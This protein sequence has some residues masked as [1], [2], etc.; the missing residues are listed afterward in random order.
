MSACICILTAV[1]VVE[2]V[3]GGLLSIFYLTQLSHSDI[4][5]VGSMQMNDKEGAGYITLEEAMQIMYLRYGR[6]ACDQ[7][8]DTLTLERSWRI[9]VLCLP[10]GPS[11][12]A[13]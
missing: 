12:C 10:Q 11:G 6:C 3:V 7:H 4:S 8:A 5:S 1:Q 13:A 2:F 9:S